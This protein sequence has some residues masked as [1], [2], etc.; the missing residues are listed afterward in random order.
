MLKTIFEPIYRSFLGRILSKLANIY[1]KLHKP[2]MVYGINDPTTGIFR[3]YTRISSTAQIMNDYRLSIG[4]NV[5][6]WHYSIIDATE[7]IIIEDGVQIG[8][9]VGIFTHGSEHSLRLL[10]EQFVHIPNSER[11]GYTRGTINI[12]KYTFIGAGST[13]L[14]GVT[15]GKGCLIAAGTLVSNDV[16]DYAIV[17]GR[18]GKI[19]G[20]TTDI[21]A[22]KFRDYDFSSTYYDDSALKIIQ[23]KLLSDELR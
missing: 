12:G 22:Q 11:K 14:P 18:P 10:G 4:D 19:K 20:S 13:I 21:D 16:P 2:F 1:A 23:E 7:G 5:W 6:I 8:A 9:W 15:I 17:V 3:K